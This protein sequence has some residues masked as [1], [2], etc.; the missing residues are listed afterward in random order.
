MD[1]NILYLLIFIHHFFIASTRVFFG[2]GCI[3]GHSCWLYFIYYSI[4]G[5]PSIFIWYCLSNE[6]GKSAKFLSKLISTPIK[7]DPK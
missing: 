4:N 3:D 1:V 5:L 6:G 2:L 7:L